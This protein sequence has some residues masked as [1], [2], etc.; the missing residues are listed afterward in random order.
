MEA[1]LARILI[2]APLEMQKVVKVPTDHLQSCH[3]QG[4]K[5]TGNAAGFNDSVTFTGLASLPLVYPSYLTPKGIGSM[6]AAVL[7]C[8]LGFGA[9]VWFS[10]D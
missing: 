7:S 2:E 1:G 3:N 9:I 8:L 10:S 6:V 4:I 5:T